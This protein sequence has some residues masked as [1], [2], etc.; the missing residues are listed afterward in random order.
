MEKLIQA[1]FKEV[2]ENKNYD[3]SLIN[4]YFSEDYIQEVDGVTLD[5]NSFKNHIRKLK[6]KVV[7]QKVVFDNIMSDENC[8]ITKHYV[9]SILQNEEVV[10]H[11]VFAEF[12]FKNDKVVH[13]DEL[14]F[15]FEG[16]SS[17]K[18]LGSEV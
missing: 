4:K 16:D 6:E 10:K 11:K 13:C 15:L 7:E 9:T 1:V 17:Q 12:K 14:T 5:F 2:I 3:E 18:K 8:V